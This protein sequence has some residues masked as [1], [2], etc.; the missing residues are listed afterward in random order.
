M[1]ERSRRFGGGCYQEEIGQRSTDVGEDGEGM[2]LT[3]GGVEKGKVGDQ[4]LSRKAW[5]VGS[6]QR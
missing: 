3:N 4:S 1:S 2:E 6:R 5:L